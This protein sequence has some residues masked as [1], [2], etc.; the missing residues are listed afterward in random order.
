MSHHEKLLG[1]AAY[2]LQSETD[3]KSDRQK[4]DMMELANFFM[5]MAHDVHALQ[6]VGPPMSPASRAHDIRK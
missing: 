5:R 1:R 6:T 4:T 2:Y 3:S